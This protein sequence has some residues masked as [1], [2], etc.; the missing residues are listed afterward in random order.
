MS[1][2]TVA[3]VFENMAENMVKDPAKVA[4]INAIYQFNVTGD[5]SGEW[6][7]DLTG[8][9]GAV[10]PGPAENA[11]CTVTIADEDLLAIIGGSL[12]PQMAFMTG[13]VKISGDMS[14]AMKLGKILG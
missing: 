11:N 13:K 14:L 10:N 7:V 5:D 1:D 4:N 12:N 2:L 6:S 8:D 3:K 9:A